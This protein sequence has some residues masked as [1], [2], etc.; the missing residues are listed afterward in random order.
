MQETIY[1][2]PIALASICKKENIHLTHILGLGCIFTYDDE[3]PFGKEVNGFT[4]E[5]LP[6]FF[7]SSYSTVK[8]IL[9]R[10]IHLINENALNLRI[11]NANYSRKN[12]RNFI[13]KITTY[14]KTCSVP[15]LNDS[16]TRV[17]TNCFK[18]YDDQNNEEGYN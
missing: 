9:D 17:A 11:R 2:P 18:A 8:A 3:H 7:G 10:L 16:I 15:N 12:I 4:E 5:S 13:T 14:R 6:N 1:F